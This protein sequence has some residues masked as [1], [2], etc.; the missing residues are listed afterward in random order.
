M[1]RS[2]AISYDQLVIKNVY[3]RRKI[4]SR[5]W[6]CVNRESQLFWD[7]CR[8][9]VCEQVSVGIWVN[10]EQGIGLD[11][12]I[13]N[14]LLAMNQVGWAEAT[15]KCKTRNPQFHWKRTMLAL[16][17]TFA[18]D[19]FAHRKSCYQWFYSWTTLFY[20]ETPSH[21]ILA[22]SLI[23]E[24]KTPSVLCIPKP[25]SHHPTLA[26]ANSIHQKGHLLLSTSLIVTK[27]NKKKRLLDS[28]LIVHPS[29]SGEG[30]T[31]SKPWVQT[32]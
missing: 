15:R 25:I 32:L 10:E 13:K 6:S 24:K 23:I 7:L 14:D 30:L 22:S 19:D 28:K 3:K 31:E 5:L 1:R 29:N 18:I 26:R 12:V 9:S 8:R 16:S 21:S 27:T 20:L 17:I 11:L 4:L 2:L